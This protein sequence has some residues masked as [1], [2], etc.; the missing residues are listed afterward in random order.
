MRLQVRSSLLPSFGTSL[1]HENHL[2]IDSAAD[3]VEFLINTRRWAKSVIARYSTSNDM[4]GAD[5]FD[6]E[7]EGDE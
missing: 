7:E 6:E 2:K 5:L 4:F 3:F 1:I